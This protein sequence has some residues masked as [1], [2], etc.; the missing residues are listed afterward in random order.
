MCDVNKEIKTHK[1]EVCDCYCNDKPCHN[2]AVY[3]SIRH[4]RQYCL[5]HMKD[6]MSNYILK[7]ED[8]KL[9]SDY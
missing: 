3:R 1:L 5:A 2:R 8:G 4:G 6:L 7:P 9:Q